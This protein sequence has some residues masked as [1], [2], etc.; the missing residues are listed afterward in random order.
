MM[1]RVQQTL[2]NEDARQEKLD[3]VI[4]PG[5]EVEQTM[6]MVVTFVNLLLRVYFVDF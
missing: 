1:S 3:G 5:D 6:V 2:A 4:A